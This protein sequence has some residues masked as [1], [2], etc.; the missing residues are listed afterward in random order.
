MVL[1]P[2]I[3]ARVYAIRQIMHTNDDET[4]K[5]TLQCQVPEMRQD[6]VIIIDEKVLPDQKPPPGSAEAEYAAA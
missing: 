6:N 1:S 2:V 4:C 3:D 5:K